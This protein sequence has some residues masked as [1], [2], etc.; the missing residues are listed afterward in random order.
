MLILAYELIFRNLITQYIKIP[1][2][3][4]VYKR[5]PMIYMNMSL[6]FQYE[7]FH[8]SLFQVSFQLYDLY[9]AYNEIFE[10]ELLIPIINS[11]M[12]QLNDLS[13]ENL[14]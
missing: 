13:S 14:G 4:K 7:K 8:I 9:N 6:Y 1:F 5:H 3:F 11:K 10:N 12:N 2:S